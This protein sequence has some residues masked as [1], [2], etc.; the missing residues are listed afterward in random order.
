MLGSSP[1]SLA[2]HLCQPERARN[3]KRA[4]RALLYGLLPHLRWETGEARLSIALNSIDLPAG[5]S[6][7]LVIRRTKSSEQTQIRVIGAVCVRF[8]VCSRA[9]SMSQT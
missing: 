1:I 6:E 9:P 5:P 2:Y 4:E 8:C 7:V 3:L